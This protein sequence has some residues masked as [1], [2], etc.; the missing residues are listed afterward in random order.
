M[1]Y[2]DIQKKSDAELATFV[3]EKREELR[4]VRFDTTG[5]GS[6]DVKTVRSSK[7]AI[8]RALTELSVRSK[9]AS[10]SNQA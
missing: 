8:A 7:Q 4:K 3:Q 5:A 9:N 10:S 1:K 2:S 6:S